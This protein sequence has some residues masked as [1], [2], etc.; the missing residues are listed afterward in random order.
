M[1]F[2]SQ[3]KI[4]IDKA[5]VI[6]SS[7][8][9]SI[10]A[11][12]HAIYR[13]FVR[14]R[15]R[16]VYRLACTGSAFAGSIRPHRRRLRS[17]D[18]RSGRFFHPG[19]RQDAETAPTLRTVDPSMQTIDGPTQL[20]SRR[21]MSDSSSSR[22]K[23]SKDTSETDP[24]PSPLEEILHRRLPINVCKPNRQCHGRHRRRRPD[25]TNLRSSTSRD[26]EDFLDEILPELS[27]HESPKQKKPS[28]NVRTS[29][30]SWN[31]LKTLHD[32]NVNQDQRPFSGIVMH[33]GKSLTCTISDTDLYSSTC[34]VVAVC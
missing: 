28:M 7:L 34:Q 15:L 24:L 6:E 5:T 29:C 26:F 1:Y 31:R 10:P 3:K 11:Q 25:E 23:S 12:E 17:N 4:G 2:E 13:L 22:T 20:F 32:H 18:R 21:F 16:H 30:R 33:G 9:T 19:I 27:A 8:D 14:K